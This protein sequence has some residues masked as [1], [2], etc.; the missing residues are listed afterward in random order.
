MSEM[1]CKSFGMY[2]FWS[3]KIYNT[4]KLCF[5]LLLYSSSTYFD[6]V[7]FVS[8]IHIIWAFNVIDM[9]WNLQNVFNFALKP[10]NHS[11]KNEIWCLF[12]LMSQPALPC[13]T[14]PTGVSNMPHRWG[15]LDTFRNFF[16]IKNIVWWTAAIWMTFWYKVPKCLN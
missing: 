12:L 4:K 10:Y 1:N 8:K 6:G 13:P 15:M 7:S 2:I 9:L 5:L 3:W 14:C 16:K 11:K